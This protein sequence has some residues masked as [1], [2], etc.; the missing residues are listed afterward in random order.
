MWA[1]LCVR[2]LLSPRKWWN[3]SDLLHFWRENEVERILSWKSLESKTWW[4]ASSGLIIKNLFISLSSFLFSFF[5]LKWCCVLGI[6][7]PTP[8]LNGNSTWVKRRLW[9]SVQGWKGWWVTW[10]TLDRMLRVIPW[11]WSYATLKKFSSVTYCL[12]FFFFLR[13]EVLY[14]LY[15]KELLEIFKKMNFVKT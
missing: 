3:T 2:H 15:L 13:R 12:F 10:I 11:G 9:G 1:L 5:S 14:R 4:F 6:Q 8:S 7:Q